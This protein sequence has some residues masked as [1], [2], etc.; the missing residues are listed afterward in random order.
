LL[1]QHIEKDR[2]GSFFIEEE[3][4]QLAE[5]DYSLSPPDTMI[6]LHTEVDEALKG[7]SIGKKLLEHAVEYARVKN[8]KIIPLCPYVKSVFEKDPGIYKDVVKK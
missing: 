4:I 7:R 3:D 2:Q 1:I 6:I 8:Y 5:M